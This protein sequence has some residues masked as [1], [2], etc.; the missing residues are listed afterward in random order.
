[1]VKKEQQPDE[2][3]GR[4]QGLQG[5]ACIRALPEQGVGIRDVRRETER[6]P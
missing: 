4:G 1:M 5:N 2:S 6:M 3:S